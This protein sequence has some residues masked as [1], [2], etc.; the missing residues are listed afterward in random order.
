VKVFRVGGV[1]IA[2]AHGSLIVTVNGGV[3]YLLTT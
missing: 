2:E 3:L 1:K